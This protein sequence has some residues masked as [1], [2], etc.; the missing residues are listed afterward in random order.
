M[1]YPKGRP[2]SEQAKKRIS[3]TMKKRGIVPIKPFRVEHLSV[4][5]KKKIG[6]ANKGNKA[7]LGQTNSKEHREKISNSN[8]GRKWSGIMPP[9]Y[10]G[11]NNPSW[12]GGISKQKGYQPTL[13][14]KRRARKLS[15]G[16]SHTV[17]EWD[18][19]KRIFEFRC[20]SCNKSEPEIKLTKDHIIPISLGGTDNIDNIQPL[21]LSCNVKKHKKVIKYEVRK[22]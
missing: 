10:K 2:R 7:R 3:E 13:N 16:G 12:K 11:E 5:H 6:L 19:I 18:C 14:S 9:H 4:E 20:P 17:W 21:C 8:M 1:S 22:N 15:N